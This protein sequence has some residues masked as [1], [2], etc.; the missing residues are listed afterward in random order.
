MNKKKLTQ[1]KPSR[2]PSEK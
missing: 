2:P 1:E